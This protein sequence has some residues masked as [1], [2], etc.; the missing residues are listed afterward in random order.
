MKYFSRSGL[1]DGEHS[2]VELFVED[3]VVGGSAYDLHDI[4]INSLL[5]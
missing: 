4:S 3:L 5:I 2:A 1:V